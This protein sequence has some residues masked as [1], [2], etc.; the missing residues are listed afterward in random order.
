[1]R[2][3]ILDLSLYATP[4]RYRFIDGHAFLN[5]RKLDL[6]EFQDESAES[7]PNNDDS[8]PHPPNVQYATISY[9]WRGNET[10]TDDPSSPLYWKDTYGTFQVKGAEDGDPI[11]LDVLEHVCEAVKD[12]SRYLWLDRLC[13]LQ[14]SKPDKIWQ[15]TRMYS[16]YAHCEICCV[17]PGG[18]RRLVRLG[19]RTSWIDR[20]WTLQEAIAPKKTVVLFRWD[21]CMEGRL[22]QHWNEFTPKS[23]IDGQ[24]ACH[25]LEKLLKNSI[26]PGVL[27]IDGEDIRAEVGLFGPNFISISALLD[28]MPGAPSSNRDIKEQSIWRSALLRTSSRPVDMVFSIMNVFGITLDPG[29]FESNDRLGATIKLAQEILK[30]GGAANWIAAA[31]IVT[32][33]PEISTFPR[34]PETSVA[35]QA[36]VQMPDGERKLMV[37][38][39]S[40]LGGLYLSNVPSG[41]SM[42]DDGYLTIAVHATQVRKVGQESVARAHI[43]GGDG[44]AWEL[45]LLTGGSGEPSAEP[46]TYI[47]HIGSFIQAPSAAYPRYQVSDPQRAFVVQE[48]SPDRFHHVTFATFG[49]EWY[50]HIISLPKITLAIGGPNPPS[51]RA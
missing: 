13:I 15:I 45:A 27:Y 39:C 9:A 4:C 17:L 42:D 33:S 19:E 41:G 50:K 22:V 6:Y 48:H 36:Y 8:P 43:R 1:M 32:P 10:K 30:R 25:D 51:K 35:G 14:T 11:S 24:S 29:S 12:A 7:L 38:L 34:F 21:H 26:Y 37:D 44:S 46:K 3:T 18:I 2:D 40:S 49:D 5:E 31:Y 47:L 16:I 20:G 28:A 23:V